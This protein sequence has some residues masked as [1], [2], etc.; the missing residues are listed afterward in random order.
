ML[1][2]VEPKEWNEHHGRQRGLKESHEEACKG[3][4]MLLEVQKVTSAIEQQGN[5]KDGRVEHRIPV[6]IA[7][8]PEQEVYCERSWEEIQYRKGHGQEVFAGK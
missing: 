2:L 5:E 4:A 8:Y 3:I 7:P 1:T 6:Q